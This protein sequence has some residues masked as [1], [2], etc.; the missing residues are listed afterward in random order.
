MFNKMTSIS[1]PFDVGKI[2]WETP[3]LVSVNF[4]V[5]FISS[6]SICSAYSFRSLMT[7][8]FALRFSLADVVLAS[9]DMTVLAF[10]LTTLPF[11]DEAHILSFSTC[12]SKLRSVSNADDIFTTR[13]LD[14]RCVVVV[15]GV[16]VV[17]AVEVL[18][19]LPVLLWIVK[20]SRIA[21]FAFSILLEDT[22]LD[23]KKGTILS[24][25]ISVRAAASGP[26]V[27][28]LPNSSSNWVVT[29]PA[30]YGI[31]SSRPSTSS[32]SSLSVSRTSFNNSATFSSSNKPSAMM[33]CE[34]LLFFFL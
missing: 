2:I 14:R 16:A 10:A 4:C 24:S 9:V 34:R 11:T 23:S 22:P 3:L 6:R 13:S 29:T 7:S 12:S 1:F 25:R 19:L 33:V 5:L 21:A 8:C 32:S 18:P 15:V 28:S 20:P 26:F 27:L 31:T 30:M 17:V